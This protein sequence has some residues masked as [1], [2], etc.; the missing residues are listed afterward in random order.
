VAGFDLGSMLV[1]HIDFWWRQYRDRL[2]GLTDHEH[3]WTPEPGWTVRE[4]PEGWIIDD[5]DRSADPAPFTSIAWR[6]WHISV[7]CLDSYSR[8]AFGEQSG[9]D[10]M[11]WVGTAAE[12]LARTDAAWA[13]F[14]DNIAALDRAALERPI[15]DAFGGFRERSHGALALHAQAEVTH[16][17][18][19]IALLR[20]LYRLR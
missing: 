11:V 8:R 18:A 20:D 3:L 13:C 16:H 5:V 17:G 1:D 9:P 4:T 12:A 14:R 6:M 19:E 2:D 10:D 15:G 7:D